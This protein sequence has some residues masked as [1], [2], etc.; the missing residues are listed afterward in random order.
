MIGSEYNE[1]LSILY[2]AYLQLIMI[3]YVAGQLGLVMGPL[4]GGRC[5]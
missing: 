4:I 2:V 3:R 5:A 1:F